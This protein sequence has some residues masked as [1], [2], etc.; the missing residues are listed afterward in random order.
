MIDLLITDTVISGDERRMD[1]G[2]SSGKI[3]FVTPC[4]ERKTEASR[5]VR[6]KGGLLL[7]GFV[8]PHIHLEKAYLLDSMDREAESL[9]DA[10]QITSKLKSSFT[11]ED[12]YRRSL[13]V[14]REAVRNGVTHM[15]CHAEVDP[16]LGLRAVESA[17]RL[18]QALKHQLDLQVV[19]FP[20]EGV[21]KSPGTAE[22]MEEAIRMGADVIGGI[23][24]Q[25]ADLGEHL[26]FAFGLAW[27][28]GKSLD[29]HADF[30]VDSNDRAV[31]EIAK[32]T[33][34]AGMQGHVAAGHLTSLGS[35]PEHEAL[36]IGELLCLAGISVITLPMTDLF[37]NGREGS[38]GHHRGLTPVK[39]LQDCGVNVA[40]GVNNV[41]NPFTPFGKADPIEAAWLLAV[42][43]YMGSK[44]DA[45]I[46]TNMLTHNAAQALGIEN[47]GVKVG[48]P[49]DMVLFRERSERE[50]LLNKPE[51]RT[52]WKSGLQV[53]CTDSKLLELPWLSD[54]METI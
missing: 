23:T 21:F 19:A 50:V 28:Y 6:G 24:Y 15:R 29:F 46:L 51:A 9:Q 39:L 25:D 30:S 36:A 42:T 40:I 53:A 22:L 48:A 45:L 33:I 49:A 26:D 17:L 13:V 54:G 41:R 11:K 52:V 34:A 18:K 10:I 27:K 32:R 7:P 44:R 35:L 1:V 2:I 16:V 38:E 12:I 31:V 37:L 5:L 8:E 20:Q 4:G 14:I 43:S 47:Y 3:T